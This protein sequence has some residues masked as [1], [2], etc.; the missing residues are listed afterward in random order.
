M[1]KG[2]I[3]QRMVHSSPLAESKIQKKTCATAW[4]DDRCRGCLEIKEAAISLSPRRGTEPPKPWP[5]SPVLN[6]FPA[7]LTSKRL[8]LCLHSLPFFN[9]NLKLSSTGEQRLL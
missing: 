8:I 2:T 6:F 5:H 3:S 1:R 9:V 7:A 4:D